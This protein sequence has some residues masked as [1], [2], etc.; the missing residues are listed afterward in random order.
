MHYPA[1]YFNVPV[2]NCFKLLIV[3]TRIGL[4]NSKTFVYICHL[5]LGP[6]VY[7]ALTQ[8]FDPL[9]LVI[10]TQ[11]RIT[12]THSS[13][14]P[15]DHIPLHL[16]IFICPSTL[17][18]CSSTHVCHIL[19]IKCNLHQTTSVQDYLPLVLIGHYHK[20]AVVLFY[21][22]VMYWDQ[23]KLHENNEFS[24][25]V[26]SFILWSLWSSKHLTSGW[27]D[28]NKTET[29]NCQSIWSAPLNTDHSC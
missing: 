17:V 21:H 8:D 25:A 7:S 2:L 15:E 24:P 4:T 12:V 26:T 27:R 5:Q 11:R 23:R 1:K 29:T 16:F 28:K 10:L 3:Q 6:F 9:L 13:G 14:H 18:S 20:M 22:I 19:M